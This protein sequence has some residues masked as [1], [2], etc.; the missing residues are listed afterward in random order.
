MLIS[1]RNFQATSSILASYLITMNLI[2]RSIDSYHRCFFPSIKSYKILAEEPLRYGLYLRM[3]P[4][5]KV[6]SYL[7][8]SAVDGGN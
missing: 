5:P 4:M 1:L 7:Q 3:L 2:L 6:L 8:K